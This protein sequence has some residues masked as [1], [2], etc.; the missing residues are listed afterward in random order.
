MRSTWWLALVA[1]VVLAGS[2]RFSAGVAGSKSARSRP[3]QVR[4]ER[5]LDP[6]EEVEGWGRNAS[7][8]RKMALGHA[9]EKVRELLR[10]RFGGLEWV[11]PED[12]LD[13]DLLGRYGVIKETGEPKEDERVG[14]DRW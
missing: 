12:R 10:K 1:F 7:D 6:G 13:N 4:A 3:P 2:A 11:P 8:A 9:Q 14:P 5:S